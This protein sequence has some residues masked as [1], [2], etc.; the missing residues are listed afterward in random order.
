MNQPENYSVVDSPFGGKRLIFKRLDKNMDRAWQAEKPAH[1][2]I[3]PPIDERIPN[4]D[5]LPQAFPDVKD[6]TISVGKVQN[7][8]AIDRLVNLKSLSFSGLVKKGPELSGLTNLVDAHLRWWEGCESV[9]SNP[10]LVTLGLYESKWTELPSFSRLGKL[11]GFS[12]SNCRNMADLSTLSSAPGLKQLSLAVLP[13][14]NR[15]DFLSDLRKLKQ[16]WIHSLKHVEDFSSISNLRNLRILL[17]QELGAVEG[18]SAIG[19]CRELIFFDFVGS[20]PRDLD[21]AFLD[22]LEKL[23]GLYFENKRSYARKRE[24][25]PAWGKGV[26]L[27]SLEREVLGED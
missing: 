22:K 5:F 27:P 4:L 25:Y 17:M 6:L 24:S 21:L 12:L 2:V 14:V 15:L 19:N 23:R 11:E 9:F 3:S 26:D 10:S 13:K 20:Y 18:M 8:E 1:V 7:A 16:L